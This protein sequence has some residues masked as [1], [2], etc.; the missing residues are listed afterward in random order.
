MIFLNTFLL[1]KLWCDFKSIFL[2][3]NVSL[4]L[5]AQILFYQFKNDLQFYTSLLLFSSPLNDTQFENTLSTK[6]CSIKSAIYSLSSIKMQRNCVSWCSCFSYH[7]KTGEG[8]SS[9]YRW[10][11]LS[12]M[13]L[14]PYYACLGHC[15]DGTLLP[16]R[17]AF[18]A[19]AT[20]ITS[21]RGYSTMQQA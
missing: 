17:C 13:H 2:R 4:V 8:Q 18:Y 9:P 19:V 14:I 7:R 1:W 5:L 20:I 16:L 10:A 15:H 21:T 12:D 11:I 6:K 3:K